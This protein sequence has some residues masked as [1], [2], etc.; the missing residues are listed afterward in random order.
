M[1]YQK[2]ADKKTTEKYAYDGVTTEQ[3]TENG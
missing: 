1:H 3:K 2:K